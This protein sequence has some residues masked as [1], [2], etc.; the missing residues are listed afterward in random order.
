[1]VKHRKS[2]LLSWVLQSKTKRSFKKQNPT[3]LLLTSQNRVVFGKSD[4]KKSI[5]QIG[6]NL[7]ISKVL[8]DS[9]RICEWK[10]IVLKNSDFIISVQKKSE[11]ACTFIPK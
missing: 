7:N 6:N 11:L 1:M 3:Q 9:E 10:D 8:K 4:V 5:F 2:Y